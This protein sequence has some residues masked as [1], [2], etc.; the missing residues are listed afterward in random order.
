MFFVFL[1]KI[2]KDIWRG[3]VSVAYFFENLVKAVYLFYVREV[4]SLKEEYVLEVGII[5]AVLFGLFCGNILATKVD[6]AL[7]RKVMLVILMGGSA[8]MI[9]S[10][11]ND[12]TS[13]LILSGLSISYF[14]FFML[15][16]LQP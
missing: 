7:W 10:G 5:I 4:I 13:V 1:S 3:T 12:L 8:L 9:T 11:L 16:R 2:D 6:T 15:F 14:V